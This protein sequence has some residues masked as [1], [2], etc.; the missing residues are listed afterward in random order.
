MIVCYE[1]WKNIERTS[2]VAYIFIKKHNGDI[3]KNTIL[4]KVQESFKLTLVSIT[5]DN[6]QVY[7]DNIYVTSELA[8]LVILLGKECSSPK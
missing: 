3:L 1:V 8:F 7:I 4:D 6:H 2:K 5:I